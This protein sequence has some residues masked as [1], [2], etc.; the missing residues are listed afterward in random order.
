[1]SDIITLIGPLQAEVGQRFVYQGA[2]DGPDAQCAPCKLHSI[3]FNLKPGETYEVKAVRSKDHPC[4]LHESGTARVV[5]VA[6]APH[7]AI[8][9]ARGLVAGETFLYPDR[10][11]PNRGC[12]LW[13]R[14]V[15][16][17]ARPGYAYR[18]ETVGDM[19]DCPLGLELRH[20]QLAPR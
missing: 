5:E 6:T 12:A 17:T 19:A 8:L 7:D 18:V 9:P 11:C 16:G 15:G 3:C 2:N 14:C 1:M 20:A 13:K 10:E 4:Y